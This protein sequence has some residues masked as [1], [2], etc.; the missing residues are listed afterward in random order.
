MGSDRCRTRSEY[1]PIWPFPPSSASPSVPHSIGGCSVAICLLSVMHMAQHH[2]FILRW[3]QG[4]SSIDSGLTLRVPTSV[5][6]SSRRPIV[7]LTN[8]TSAS[9]IDYRSGR[10][11]NRD[12]AGGHVPDPVTMGC[13]RRR[14]P[15]ICVPLEVSDDQGGR[16]A[17]TCRFGDDSLLCFAVRGGGL[18]W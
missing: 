4:V 8:L 14:R 6:V 12:V 1:Y 7:S 11:A 3:A 16:G 15:R 9:H 10:N 17:K 13:H 5:C 18:C 2:V